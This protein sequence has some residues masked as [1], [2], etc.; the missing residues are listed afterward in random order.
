MSWF[1]WLYILFACMSSPII[2]NAFREIRWSSIDRPDDVTWEMGLPVGMKYM[3][4]HSLQRLS[5]T[6]RSL[7]AYIALMN[8]TSLR[9]FTH[10]RPAFRTASFRP[11]TTTP[12]RQFSMSTSNSTDFKPNWASEDGSFKRQVSSFRDSIE[13]GGKFEPEKGKSG[14]RGRFEDVVRGRKLIDD[15]IGQSY[16]AGRYHLYVCN[17]W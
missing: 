12:K 7:T 15:R 6:V 8:K 4:T 5:S 14:W 17:A 1:T 11:T 9:L 3:T 13:K 2:H 10:L 16:F